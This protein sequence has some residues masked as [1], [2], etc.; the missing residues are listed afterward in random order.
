[1]TAEIPEKRSG[2]APSEAELLETVFL[3][4]LEEHDG[5]CLD[6]EPERL[7]LAAVLNQALISA[8][9]DGTINPMFLAKKQDEVGSAS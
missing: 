7:Q 2:Q 4:I 1:M 9:R 8:V 5:L 6:N 3:S